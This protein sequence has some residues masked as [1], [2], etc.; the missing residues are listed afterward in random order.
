MARD[1]QEITVDSIILRPIQTGVTLEMGY[2]DEDGD[3]ASDTWAFVDW[4]GA[5]DWLAEFV[6]EEE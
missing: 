2:K 1:L 3:Y 4:A 5:L 6:G